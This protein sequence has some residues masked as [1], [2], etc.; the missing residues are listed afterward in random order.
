MT[1]NCAVCEMELETEDAVGTFVVDEVRYYFCT[2]KCQQ[3]FH[4]NP[5]LYTVDWDEE[6]P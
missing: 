5:E 3:E 2:E 4:E 1:V 6:E